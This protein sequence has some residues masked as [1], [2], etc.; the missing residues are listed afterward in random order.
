MWPLPL[1][2][3]TLRKQSKKN[4]ITRWS[5]VLVRVYLESSLA[6][7]AS[8][9]NQVTP[10]G[11]FLA[12]YCFLFCSLYCAGSLYCFLYCA[13]QLFR[14]PNGVRRVNRANDEEAAAV[15]RELNNSQN[16]LF[17]LLSIASLSSLSSRAASS[18]ILFPHFSPNYVS[19][20]VQNRNI[21]IG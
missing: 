9:G 15:R 13:G 4:P 12:L 19:T 3:D 17:S 6:V 20:G 8:S 10:G 5:S 16:L 21:Q 7:P 14:R 18:T 11:R 1:E 2:P